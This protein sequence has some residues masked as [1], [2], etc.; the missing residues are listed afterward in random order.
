MTSRMKKPHRSSRASEKNRLICTERKKS[1]GI[2]K[3]KAIHTFK[4][5]PVG[6]VCL[7]R[8][9]IL[10]IIFHSIL[11][12]MISHN[13]TTNMDVRRVAELFTTSRSPGRL[14]FN[15]TDVLGIVSKNEFLSKAES[16]ALPFPQRLTLNLSNH[17]F[18]DTVIFL[19][20]TSTINPSWKY[21]RKKT[22]KRYLKGGVLVNSSIDI[23]I[24]GT[25]NRME[26]VL[27]QKETWAS[28]PFRRYFFLATEY[29]DLDPKCEERHADESNI[30][31]AVSFCKSHGL[32]TSHGN[33]LRT[34]FK[35]YYARVQ[36][37]LKKKNPGG[38]L[39]AHR[40]PS[41]A[42]AK[43]AELYSSVGKDI[44][45]DYLFIGDDDTY[46]NLQHILDALVR[47]PQYLESIGISQEHS[48]FPTQDTPVVW[49]GCRVRLPAQQVNFTFG[50]GGFG[51]FFSKASLERLFQP[52]YCSSVRASDST[53]EFEKSA[54]ERILN[55]E[56]SLIGENKYYKY[57]MSLM[58]IWKAM[59]S[60][61]SFCMH[62]DW[63]FGYFTNFYNIS[64]H[65][66]SGGS[67]WFDNNSMK[68]LPEARLHTLFDSEMYR[69]PEGL[70]R[71]DNGN[72]PKN[73]TIC[74]KLSSANLTDIHERGG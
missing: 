16:F 56:D 5:M 13:I 39:C 53:S 45:P 47:Q 54:C 29:D 15:E 69:N 63:I 59:S 49:A 28:H 66:V 8:T 1:V 50:F 4:C 3:D 37:L 57:G 68:D 44:L 42:L 19:N 35:N 27:A 25:K 26:N 22:N 10:A 52:L 12:L 51:Y 38:W 2:E 41:I 34:A 48:V 46:V 20:E 40:R 55:P 11:T 58:D 72:C 61:E 30:S 21:Q 70:C 23:I 14:A 71:Y 60:A 67:N 73:A 24:I 74:H 32:D 7:M 36:W 64:R 18:T 65:T 62:A 43:V 17:K 31:R 9:L 33:T 6:G